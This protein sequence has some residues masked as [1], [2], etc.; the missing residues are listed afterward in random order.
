MSMKRIKAAVVT[1][2]SVALILTS[3]LSAGPAFSREPE[4]DAGKFVL[5]V[6]YSG[7]ALFADQRIDEFE[8]DRRFARLIAENLDT[9]RIARFVL[10]RYWNAASER[11]RDDFIEVYPTY[12]ARAFGERIGQ[13]SGAMVSIS[14]VKPTD[15]EIRVTTTIEFLGPRPT[16]ANVSKTEITWL[17]RSTPDGL[18]IEDIDYQGISLELQQRTDLTGTITRVGET[19]AGLVRFILESLTNS[20]FKPIAPDAAH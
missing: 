4:S 10:G 7:M 15:G 17:V 13:F 2:I 18:K 20:P 12:L 1:A 3:L 9:P 16:M 5:G 8:R 6:L 11:E 19:V 14:N